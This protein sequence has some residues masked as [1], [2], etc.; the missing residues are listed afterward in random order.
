MQVVVL[1]GGRGV[2][3]RPL[4]NRLPKPMLPID[5]RPFLQYV[6]EFI[7]SC[8]SIDVLLLVGYLGSKI[9][10]YFADGS[11]FALNINYSYEQSPL[12]TAGALKNA[13]RK[14]Q[15]EFVLLYGD[16]YL[17]INYKRLLR[18]FHQR[19]CLGMMTVYNNCRQISSNNTAVSKTGMVVGY[20]KDN[21]SGM[22]HLD[23]GV[24]V[25]KKEI[26]RFIPKHKVCS[27]EKAILPKLIKA[28]QLYA[29]VTNKRFYDI[30]SNEGL[31]KIKE[32][33]R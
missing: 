8:I 3:L 14:L 21:S 16:T 32:V 28:R 24:M 19:N 9:E 2:R 15:D 18:A 5:G 17:P 1:V 31:L 10:A 26:V 30:G 33:L 13:E 12:D 23:A 20:N 7:Q 29:F 25:F 22:T 11:D 27:L 4:T 6:L